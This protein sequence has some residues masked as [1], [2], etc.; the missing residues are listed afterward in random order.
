MVAN[1]E[2]LQTNLFVAQI[3]KNYCTATCY[4]PIGSWET[5]GHLVDLEELLHLLLI[6]FVVKDF[7]KCT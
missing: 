5:A 7:G 6:C 2:V 1:K 3:T 4:I